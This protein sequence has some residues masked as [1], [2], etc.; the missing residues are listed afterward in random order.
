MKIIPILQNRNVIAKL[1]VSDLPELRDNENAKHYGLF[2]IPTYSSL[3][4]STV[5]GAWEVTFDPVNRFFATLDEKTQTAIAMAFLVMHQRILDYGHQTDYSNPSKTMNDIGQILVD[6]NAEIQLC[7]RIKQFATANLPV[8]NYDKAGSRPQDRP[9]TTIYPHE[10]EDLLAI[11]V[12]CKMLSPLFG[13]AMNL[14]VTRPGLDKDLKEI[15]TSRLI[16][17]VLEVQYPDF[18]AKL[19]RILQRTIQ[20]TFKQD[21]TAVFRGTTPDSLM[22]VISASLYVRSLVNVDLYY[23]QGTGNLAIYVFS[24]IKESI[25]AKRSAGGP[26]RVTYQHREPTDY[27]DTSPNNVSQ[28]EVDSITSTAALDTDAIIRSQLDMIIGRGLRHHDLDAAVYEQTAEFYRTHHY[29]LSALNQTFVFGF[30]GPQFSGAKTLQ[31]ITAEQYNQLLA[32]VQLLA[33]KSGFPML[34]HLLTA[35]RSMTVKTTTTE[36]EQYVEIY[37]THTYEYVNCAGRFAA[38]GQKVWADGMKHVVTDV[39]G[40]EWKFNT[41]DAIWEVAGEQSLNGSVIQVQKCLAQELSAFCAKYIFDIEPA[42]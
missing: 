1:D 5:S 31:M 12:L 25:G 14:F 35:V 6:L 23:K 42:E 28:Y 26:N 32:F 30:F 34:G 22:T 3:K 7:N 4:R 24:T 16:R 13:V 37:H 21:I 29:N 8:G 10:G 20:S 19:N 2:S 41:A 33:F 17:P 15:Y 39:I 36:A 18:M 11:T 38:A 40:N 9:E 27:G